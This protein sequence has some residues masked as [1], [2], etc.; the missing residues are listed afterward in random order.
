MAFTNETKYFSDEEIR[1]LLSGI[2][3][4]NYLKEFRDDIVQ[5]I[6]GLQHVIVC[7]E[8]AISRSGYGP[9]RAGNLKDHREYFE[10]PLNVKIRIYKHGRAYKSPLYGNSQACN[11]TTRSELRSD[12]QRI[13]D[14][15]KLDSSRDSKES[16][17][18]EQDDYSICITPSVV[19]KF[20]NPQYSGISLW[21]DLSHP[22]N[23]QKEHQEHIDELPQVI[24]GRY[25]EHNGEKLEI[26]HVL[27]FGCQIMN[28]KDD[29]I[30]EIQCYHTV[31]IYPKLYGRT[32]YL[33]NLPGPEIEKKG[34]LPLLKQNASLNNVVYQR[35]MEKCQISKKLS[36][37][38]I[39]KT[40]PHH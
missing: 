23:Y 12:P 7:A 40:Y 35:T 5:D 14:P 22:K 34:Y 24:D 28:Q 15:T 18:K 38:Q 9:W 25:I 4:Y 32:M 2:T 16:Q 1:K 3:K 13:F 19:P 29:G 26:D 27:D 10:G 33:F 37:D 20:D 31:Y 17:A 8:I 39:D 30:K 6:N 11:P 21:I 36:K